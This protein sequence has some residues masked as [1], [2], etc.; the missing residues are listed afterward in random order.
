MKDM[1]KKH[2]EGNVAFESSECLYIEISTDDLISLQAQRNCTGKK[3]LPFIYDN[4]LAHPYQNK[5]PVQLYRNYVSL[6][7]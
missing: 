1:K 2:A 6:S 3:L 4:E 7:K 5:I